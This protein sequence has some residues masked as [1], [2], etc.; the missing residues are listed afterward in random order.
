[1]HFSRIGLPL[2]GLALL[3]ISSA[4]ADES[5]PQ[6]SFGERRSAVVDSVEASIWIDAQPQK[7]WDA[8]VGDF[9][10]WWPHCYKTSSHCFI[11]ARAGGRIWERFDERDQGAVYGH[12]LYVEEPVVL[13]ADGQWGMPGTAVS[14]GTWRF[15]EKDGGTLFR[16]R[17][18]VMGG[19]GE[20]TGFDGRQEAYIGLMKQLKR[21][22]E[23]G[24]RIDRAAEAR[25]AEAQAAAAAEAAKQ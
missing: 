21:L 17:G 19:F 15:E 1:M 3:F 25:E 9:D 22:V 5:G 8:A 10:G 7:V 23:T 6:A 24:E 18:E 11:E 16:I 13:K 12:V 14:G 4:A 20:Q 2:A